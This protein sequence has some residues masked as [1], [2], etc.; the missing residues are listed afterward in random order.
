MKKEKN[1]NHKKNNNYVYLAQD[2]DVFVCFINRNIVV[3]HLFLLCYLQNVCFCRMF[4][5]DNV[6]CFFFFS[7]VAELN[8]YFMM[9]KQNSMLTIHL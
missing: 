9:K 4:I 3:I 1:R 7:A 2:S 5:C 6:F 8:V